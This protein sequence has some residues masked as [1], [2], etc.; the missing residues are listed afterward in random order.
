MSSTNVAF[1][2]RIKRV[3]NLRCIVEKALILAYYNFEE[4]MLF[5]AKVA[6]L[7]SLTVKIYGL[8]FQPALTQLFQQSKFSK[9]SIL[10]FRTHSE[11]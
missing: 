6:M 1:L 4:Y 3:V 10:V 7:R 11:K 8:N 5:I 9:V 2:M